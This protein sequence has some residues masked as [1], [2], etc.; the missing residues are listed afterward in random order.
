MSLFELVPVVVGI[1][2]GA[3]IYLALRWI[4]SRAAPMSDA[5]RTPSENA[6]RV[7]L[8]LAWAWGDITILEV[9]SRL[10]HDVYMDLALGLREYVRR[11]EYGRRSAAISS[12]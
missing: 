5:V 8:A 6:E 3:L 4:S 9:R 2:C 10:G 1:V 7:E 12:A 11:R